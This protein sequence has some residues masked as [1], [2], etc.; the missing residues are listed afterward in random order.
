L[1][2]GGWTPLWIFPST[3]STPSQAPPSRSTPK[4][5]H[6]HKTPWA[7]AELHP[8]PS[9][10]PRLRVRPQP[11]HPPSSREIP[12]PSFLDCGGW[13]PL[14]IFPSARSIPIPSSVKPEHSRT[15]HGPKTSWA[16][17][18]L[19]P[20][21]SAPSRLRVRSQP[22]HPPSSRA[23]YPPCLPQAVQQMSPGF[24]PH[25][26]PA[27]FPP[28]S[29]CAFT[30]GAKPTMLKYLSLAHGSASLGLPSFDNCGLWVKITAETSFSPC[31]S[32]VDL[33]IF[34]TTKKNQTSDSR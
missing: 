15:S 4:H 31:L 24:H 19:S 5:P 17:A 6:G 26:A 20:Q 18:E 21:P 27:T 34:T 1:D 16:T 25:T 2:C 11:N 10:S 9:A 3:R 28:Q 13:T 12:D 30:R 23:P 29:P 7:T 33:S 22:N 14:W 32:K 8:Q